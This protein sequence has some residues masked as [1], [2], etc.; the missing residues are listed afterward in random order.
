MRRSPRTQARYERQGPRSGGIRVHDPK[1]M[2]YLTAHPE[3]GGTQLVMRVYEALES[4]R[5]PFYYSYNLGDSLATPGIREQ[6][7]PHF[8]IPSINT[9]IIVQGGHW[10]EDAGRLQSTALAIALMEYAGIKVLFWGEP[11]IQSRG[12]HDMI[13]SEPM[14]RLAMGTGLPLP[15]N[16]RTLRYRDYYSQPPRPPRRGRV[17][18]TRGKRRP[19]R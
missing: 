4:A 18:S 15:T 11:E 7:R 10:F 16:Y 3:L 9:A 8:F 12:V 19:K 1:Y 17:V 2:D 5:I 6:V 13:L 14:L